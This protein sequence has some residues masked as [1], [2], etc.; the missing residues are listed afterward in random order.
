MKGLKKLLAVMLAMAMVVGLF[1]A[2]PAEAKSKK[3]LVG[4]PCQIN[5]N[6]WVDMWAYGSYVNN[7]VI[8]NINKELYEN[9]NT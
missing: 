4:I 5:G 1:A 6:A 9:Q 3:K 7:S 2:M 8:A